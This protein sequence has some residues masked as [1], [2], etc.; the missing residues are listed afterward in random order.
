MALYS[1]ETFTI[2]TNTLPSFVDTCGV[3]FHTISLSSMRFGPVLAAY[4]TK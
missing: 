2:L 4:K 1:E 3:P